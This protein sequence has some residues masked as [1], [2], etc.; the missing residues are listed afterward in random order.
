LPLV[1][2]NDTALDLTGWVTL[3]NQSGATYDNAKLTLMAG[4]VRRSTPRRPAAS[5]YAAAK[6]M[7][8]AP[9]P[10]IPGEELLRVS[11]VHDGAADHYPR[12]RDQTAIPAQRIRRAR[13]QGDDLRRPRDWWRSWWYPAGRA[14]R[15]RYDSST[16]HKVNVVLQS[17]TPRRITLAC[18]CPRQVRV[19]KLDDDGSQQLSARTMI[20]S[21]R[22]RTRRSA[23]HRRRV[24]RRL[25]TTSGT[26]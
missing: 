25:E 23:L 18:P 4:D 17:P 3:N 14:S 26:N 24:R 7:A 19:Y 11:P 12:Q 20:D 21:P 10:Q 13:Y 9:A 1:N 6:E 15:R 8:A 2:K 22:P 5:F 16:Y